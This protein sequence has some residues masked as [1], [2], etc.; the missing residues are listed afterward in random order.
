MF[1]KLLGGCLLFVFVATVL[2][3]VAAYL[4][5]YRPVKA[6]VVELQE[7][8]LEFQQIIDL[9]AEVNNSDPFFPP[10]SG[11]LTAEQVERFVAVRRDMEAQIGP[12]GAEFET[13]MEVTRDFIESAEGSIEQPAELVGMLRG[14]PDRIEEFVDRYVVLKRAQVDALNAHHVSLEEHAWVTKTFYTAAGYE[15]STI[16]VREL[17]RELEQLQ[18]SDPW[19]VELDIELPEEIG[20][21][22]PTDAKVPDVNRDLVAPYA[23]ESMTWMRL[24]GFGL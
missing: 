23:E 8:A 24:A 4:F 3:A 2:I 1:K 22:T 5:V 12:A 15:L 14:V 21:A 9:D 18:G 16:N 7:V 13:Y 11:E 6:Y 17:R 19:A 20:G 10:E